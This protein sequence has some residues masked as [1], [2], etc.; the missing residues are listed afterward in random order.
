MSRLHDISK[1]KFNDIFITLLLLLLF[2]LINGP[3]STEADEPIY[4]PFCTGTKV[5]PNGTSFETNRKLLLSSLPS[6]T[7][8]SGGFYIASIGI[9]D[10]HGLA[11]CRGDLTQEEC[12][13][14][15]NNG[16]KRIIDEC[17][18]SSSAT[19]FYEVCH[20]RYSDVNFFSEM[21]YAAKYPTR[22]NLN[23]KSSNNSYNWNSTEQTIVGSKIYSLVLDKLISEIVSEAP[24]SGKMFSAKEANV[25]ST[26]SKLYG[27]GQCTRD[28]SKD[29]CHQCLTQAQGDIA[30]DD[31][32]EGGFVVDNSCNLRYELY[33]FYRVQ[34][35]PGKKRRAITI[36]VSISVLIFVVLGSWAYCRYGKSKRDHGAS[37]IIMLHNNF[38]GP[39]PIELPPLRNAQNDEEISPDDNKELPL[40]DF[41]TIK[42][43]T[44]DF[45][46][47]NKLG[48]GGF[49]AVYKGTLPDGREIAV[50]RLSR[51]SWQGLEEFKNEVI[52]IARL[53][54]RNLVKLLGYGIY[55]EEK[56]LI[57]EF[58]PN[59]SLDLFIF[60]E[61][62]RSQLDWETRLNIIHGIA[63]GILYLHEDSRLKIIHRDL[64]PNNVLLDHEMNAK[65]S[66]FGMARIFGEKQSEASTRRVVGTCGYMP[67]EY[68]MEGIFSVKSDVFSFGVV[69]LEI[70]SGK[71]SNGFY[72]TEH[73]QTLLNY[74]WNLW[75]EGK[76]LDF[77]DQFLIEFASAPA[78]EL[79]RCLHIGLLCVQEDAADRP[80]MSYVLVMLGSDKSIDLPQPTHPA[81]SVGRF[82]SG[83]M[84]QSSSSN[85]LYSVND[86]TVSNF[87]AR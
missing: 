83:L 12:L 49:G 71:R 67:P 11:L 47:S 66:D 19:I 18:S 56:L 45:A 63:R 4:S 31:G 17:P 32:N 39:N 65:I 38:G 43:A 53:Q 14:C 87:T 72:L 1:T 8:V 78:E 35:L 28:L 54:H 85:N 62:N 7:S 13:N 10:V 27:L 61:T 52:L 9:P 21:V 69:L 30:T 33:P 64:K 73:A 57:Y 42:V 48:Q 79:L 75:N 44:D 37:Q 81:F 36:T 6:N 50:K 25:E 51:K 58:M 5:T 55:G 59:K 46:D 26:S 80:T 77:I 86:L 16:S 2:L 82:A 70:L 41:I 23:N 74:A 60:D 40:M 15:V 34:H 84:G 3:S 24:D 22:G 20:V 29:K 76:G 68:A